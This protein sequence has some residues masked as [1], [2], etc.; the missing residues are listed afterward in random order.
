MFDSI[1]SHSN[2]SFGY[3]ATFVYF[4]QRSLWICYAARCVHFTVFPGR[5]GALFFL[6]EQMHTSSSTFIKKIKP[7][8]CR[9][10]SM[11]LSYITKT[12]LQDRLLRHQFSQCRL[13]IVIDELG[14]FHQQLYH[15]P[16]LKGPIIQH[17]QRISTV[18][19]WLL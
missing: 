11:P 3:S 19:W 5:R 2:P 16:S 6:R 18:F 8:V 14:P 4:G 1:T 17:K 15:T 13:L 12:R 9:Y 7:F 10:I